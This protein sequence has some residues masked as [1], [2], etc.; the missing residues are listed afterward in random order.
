M[1][2]L[3]FFLAF[4]WLWLFITELARGPSSLPQWQQVAMTC[5]WVAFIVEFLLKLYLAPRRLRYVIQNWITVI[6][7]IIPAFRAVRLLRALRILRLSRVVTTTRLVRALTTTKRA[8]SELRDAQGPTPEPEMHVAILAAVSREG[9]LPGCQQ[10][11]QRI[12]EDARCEIASATG[13]SWLFHQV[14]PVVL[15]TNTPRQATDFIEVASLR[16]VEGPYDMVLVITDAGLLSRRRRSVPGLVSSTS[17]IAVISTRYLTATARGQAS[18]P[19]G[20]EAVRWNAG[21]LLLHLLGRIGG[22]QPDKRRPGSVS[23]PFVFRASR[24]VLP[25]FDQRER[26][27]LARVGSRM[28]E[29]ELQGGTPLAALIFH[30]LMAMRHPLDVLKPLLRNRA[31]LLPLSLPSLATAAVAPSFLLVFTAE[32]WDVGLGMSNSVATLYATISI[33]AASFY[34][35]QAQS[36][37]LPRKAKRTLTEHLAVANS[38]IFLSILLACIGLFL[39]VGVLMLLIELFIFPSGLVQTWPTLD[40]PDFGFDDTLRLAAFISTVGVT[41]GALAGGFESRTVIQN[42]ALFEDEGQPSQ[43]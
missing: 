38:V 24:R 41:T 11:G 30:I 33:L 23:T 18:Y 29:R 12:T 17:R 39:M 26:T 21:A 34:L 7:L 10:L 32:I 22:L 9:D 20:D 1:E 6:A 36:L 35:S 2:P 14:E 16:M 4:V 28:P 13:I 25:R 27:H 43:A 15:D 40:Q 42:L 37:F 3:M 8:Y 19:L 31:L 5:I